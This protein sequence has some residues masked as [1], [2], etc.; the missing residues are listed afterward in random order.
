MGVKMGVLNRDE[1]LNRINDKDRNKND[2]KYKLI[3]TPLLSIDQIGPASIDIRLGSS[4]IIPNKT[5][6]ESQD[7]TNSKIVKQVEHRGYNHIRLRYHSKFVL[8]L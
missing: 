3:I 6:V 2:Y 5:Y 8:Y 7:V 1:I 4:I